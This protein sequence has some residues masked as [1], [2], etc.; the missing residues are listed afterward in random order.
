MATLILLAL[1]AGLMAADPDPCTNYV[2]LDDDRRMAHNTVKY[3]SCIF[4]DHQLKTLWYR[5]VST[6]NN[7]LV[8]LRMYQ[9]CP[10]TQSCGTDRPVWLKGTHP[11]VADGIVSR[12]ACVPNFTEEYK[13]CC[14]REIDIRVKNCGAYFVYQLNK[15]HICEEVYCSA[16]YPS[17]LRRPKLRGPKI[18]KTA[19]G[20]EEFRFGCHIPYPA[21]DADVFFMVR[22]LFDGKPSPVAPMSQIYYV[23]GTSRVHYMK[24]IHMLPAAYHMNKHVSCSVQPF[25]YPQWSNPHGGKLWESNSYFAGIQF[26]PPVVRVEEKMQAVKVK[27]ISTIPVLC[28][29]PNADPS[30]C[31]VDFNLDLGEGNEVVA[32]ECSLQLTRA[33]WRDR[34]KRATVSTKLLSVRDFVSDG[35]KNVSAVFQ[36]LSAVQ[37]P[38]FHQLQ[39]PDIRV[40][41]S[42]DATAMCS[43]TG[44]PHCTPFDRK[45]TFH[46]Y[47]V[48]EFVLAKSTSRPFE[49]HMRT[50]KCNSRGASCICGVAAREGNDVILIDGCHS[51]GLKMKQMRVTTHVKSNSQLAAGTRIKRNKDGRIIEVFF[52][53]GAYLK[54]LSNRRSL[55]VYLTV[56]SDDFENTA[57]ICGVFN[58]NGSDDLTGSDG[59]KHRFERIPYVFT[60]SW[61]IQKGHS[62]FDQLPPP[63]PSASTN[64]PAFCQCNRR[65][66]NIDCRPENRQRNPVRKINRNKDITDEVNRKSRLRRS[67]TF[68]DTATDSDMTYNYD[69]GDLNATAV[70]VK[71][72]SSAQMKAAIKL[73]T[74]AAKASSAFTPC[75]KSGLVNVQEIVD[76]CVD[77]MKI[78]NGDKTYL[79]SVAS[80]FDTICQ[81]EILKDPK[82]Y[83]AQP[84]G[85]MGIPSFISNMCSTPCKNG[86]CVNGACV[87]DKNCVGDDCSVDTTKPPI[88]FGLT[89]S[90]ACDIR[91]RPCRLV[92]LVM[93]NV[94]DTPGLW[95]RVKE[96]VNLGPFGGVL[97]M[98]RTKGHFQSYAEVSCE[99]PE[100]PVHKGLKTSSTY[101][102]SVSSDGTTWSSDVTFVV[103]DSLCQICGADGT[104]TLK[105]RTCSIN[106][107][108]YAAGEHNP[109]N[110]G[111]MCIPSLTASDWSST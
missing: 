110:R 42:S 73:C 1:I 7:K 108:C 54:V 104:C 36:K 2:T 33:H 45:E 47:S 83:T 59:V 106:G 26:N 76:G 5:M 109:V 99:I 20:V 81:E 24:D 87:C 75:E 82:Y 52:T 28:K 85:T 4:K 17:L 86:T 40:E 14:R 97:R 90:D 94:A 41:S 89:R 15:T 11:T 111:S 31:V 67:T 34:R 96:R 55:G 32:E 53:S 69:Y 3:D 98:F 10:T 88:A 91:T 29:I 56:P 25:F 38:L 101:Q 80:T 103:Y 58:G 66:G 30:K 35:T 93:G 78:T 6:T 62:L 16:K 39:P 60:E 21:H 19:Q 12:K 50:W 23:N 68:T 48:G 100:S 9:Q 95:C 84:D 72:S 65:T 92:F 51:V 13:P 77:D 102:I 44:D 27:V 64:N 18:L 63:E 37:A 74:D 43:C 79:D 57:G 105:S 46:M 107:K 22:W 71:W 49:V 61:R 70:N 8:S